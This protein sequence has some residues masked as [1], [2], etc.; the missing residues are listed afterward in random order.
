MRYLFLVMLALPTAWLR[1]ARAAEAQ[2]S[3]N[4]SPA[5]ECFKLAMNDPNVLKSD[6]SNER[7]TAEWSALRLCAGT[8]QAEAP[9]SCFKLVLGDSEILKK[10]KSKYLGATEEE[11]LRL[12]AGTSDAEA[13]VTCIKTSMGDSEVL[14]KI[15]VLN[16]GVAETG[17]LRLCTSHFY[18]G[19]RLSGP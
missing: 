2:P 11:A 3:S 15:K 7:S 8:T 10:E 14:K 17:V 6:K 19:R 18:N 13:P 9:V 5:V 1:L 4:F 16:A 12:C